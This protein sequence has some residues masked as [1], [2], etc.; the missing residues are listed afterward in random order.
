MSNQR[1]RTR[2]E[3]NERV[4]QLKDLTNKQ[5]MSCMIDALRNST[6][7]RQG[8]PWQIPRYWQEEVLC[9]A[10]KRVGRL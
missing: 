6:P 4:L 10:A 7:H 2:A 5:F 9:E 8:G 3:C 1:P